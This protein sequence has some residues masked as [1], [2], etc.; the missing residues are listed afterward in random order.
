LLLPMAF[1]NAS[2]IMPQLWKWLALAV[3]CAQGV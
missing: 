3:L 1:L 2:I